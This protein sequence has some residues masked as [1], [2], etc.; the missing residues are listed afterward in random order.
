MANVPRERERGDR[1]PGIARAFAATVHTSVEF[2]DVEVDTGS[3][4]TEHCVQTILTRVAA[5]EPQAFKALRA[6]ETAQGI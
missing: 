1:F 4:T 5:G 3:S 6:E 2:Y